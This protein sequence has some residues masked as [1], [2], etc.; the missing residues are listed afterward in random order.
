[1]IVNLQRK[2]K[3]AVADYKPFAKLLVETVD[4][5]TQRSFSVAFVSDKRMKE[6]NSFFRDKD[7]TTD[8][9]S[10]P[11][12]PEEFEPESESLGDIVI[13]LEQA[14]KQAEENKLT[15]EL[16]IKQLVLHGLLHLCG[17][18]HEVDNGEMNARELELRRELKIQG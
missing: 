17:Y 1:M 5:A 14:E 6:L 12:Q 7:S 11:V 15:L 3:I 9:L 13:S 18:D 2:V 4:E 16:E 10:F 8:V